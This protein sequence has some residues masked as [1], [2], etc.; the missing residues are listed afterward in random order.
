MLVRPEQRYGVVEPVDSTRLTHGSMPAFDQAR[1]HT[2]RTYL[3][4]IC[5][6]PGG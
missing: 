1:T 2:P 4:P 3:V 6:Y 5:V